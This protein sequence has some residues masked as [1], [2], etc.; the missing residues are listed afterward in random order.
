MLLQQRQVAPL[1]TV[2]RHCCI[3]EGALPEGRVAAAL[4][5][6]PRGPRYQ[7]KSKGVDHSFRISMH[8]EVLE[9]PVLLKRTPIRSILLHP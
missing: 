1:A 7:A 9:F 2:P 6:L 4:G 5:Y 3:N 8:N